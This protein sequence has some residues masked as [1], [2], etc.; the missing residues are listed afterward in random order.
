MPDRPT[1]RPLG[2]ATLGT[3]DRKSPWESGFTTSWHGVDHN[4][5]RIAIALMSRALTIKLGRRIDTSR[6]LTS[7]LSLFRL[8]LSLLWRLLPRCEED[9]DDVWWWRC[10]QVYFCRRTALSCF[11]CSSDKLCVTR[12]EERRWEDL[13]LRLYSRGYMCAQLCML[14]CITYVR[15]LLYHVSVSM[16]TD[17]SWE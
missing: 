4:R 17:C 11:M 9:L 6:S 12:P 2:G 1:H 3:R 7:E 15:Q 8:F 16:V 14:V 13:G 10:L 5:F